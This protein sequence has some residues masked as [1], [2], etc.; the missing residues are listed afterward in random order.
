MMYPSRPRIG[1][2]LWGALLVAALAAAPACYDFTPVTSLPP[3]PLPDSGGLPPSEEAGV[4]GGGEG[5]PAPSPCAVCA[6]ASC[7]DRLETCRDTPKCGPF[8]ECGVTL[9][10]YSPDADKLTCFTECGRVAGMTGY[11]DPAVGPALELDSCMNA[12]CAS[13]CTVP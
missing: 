7:A 3:A 8:Y 1:L 9:G 2:S 5:G 6:E 12:S 10:C 11:E 13:A 4:D